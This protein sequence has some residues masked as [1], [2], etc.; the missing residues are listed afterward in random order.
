MKKYIRDGGS[1]KS[2]LGLEVE[3]LQKEKLQL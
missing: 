3:A 2:W 1:V